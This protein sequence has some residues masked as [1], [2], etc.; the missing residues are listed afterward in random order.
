M[1]N[2]KHSLRSYFKTPFITI[3]TVFYLWIRTLFE[4]GLYLS[5]ASNNDS[6]VFQFFPKRGGGGVD[7]KNALIIKCLEI[8]VM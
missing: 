7:P 6:T 3:F 5:Q 4:L 1:A 2:L 8:Y